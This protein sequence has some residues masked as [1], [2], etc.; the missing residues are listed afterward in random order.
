L[1]LFFFSVS[2]LRAIHLLMVDPVLRFYTTAVRPRQDR[3]RVFTACCRHR[4]LARHVPSFNKA[5]HHEYSSSRGIW[6][7]STVMRFWNSASISVCRYRLVLAQ[8]RGVYSRLN[9]LISSH[10]FHFRFSALCATGKY[11]DM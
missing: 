11:V 10:V 8:H 3:P 2:Q 7:D 1:K 5:E 6:G 4:K 9:K